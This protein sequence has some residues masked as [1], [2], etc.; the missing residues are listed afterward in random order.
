MSKFLFLEGGISP[1]DQSLMIGVSKCNMHIYV[2]VE[3]L[4]LLVGGGRRGMSP[5]DLSLMIMVKE[6]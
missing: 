3:T 6:M 2:G 1:P 5:P 4:K